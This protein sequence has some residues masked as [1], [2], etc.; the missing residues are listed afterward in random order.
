M[1]ARSVRTAIAAGLLAGVLAPASAQEVGG[2]CGNLKNGYG[3]YDYITERDKLSIVEPYH[4][5]PEVEALIRGKSGYLGGD[6]DYTLRASPNHHRALLA[7]MRYGERTKRDKPPDVTYTVECYFLRAL[8]FR[9]DDAVARMLYVT[10]LNKNGRSTEAA[11]QLERTLQ[12]ADDNAYTYYNVGL[13][14]LEMKNYDKAL[15]PAQRAYA[16]GI[17]R[18]E[19][20]DGLKAAGKW[21]EPAAAAAEGPASAASAASAP[22]SAAS[23]TP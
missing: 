1:S 22:A 6:I 14:Y 17:T 15:P 3:P 4:F 9:P 8:A 13:I 5:A 16:M 20:R 19:L 2:N 23:G 11:Q 18:P 12:S 7:V 21:V 10:Y